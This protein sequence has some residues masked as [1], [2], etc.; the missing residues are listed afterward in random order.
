MKVDVLGTTFTD[1]VVKTD[2]LNMKFD[3]LVFSKH[4][5]ISAGGNGSNVAINLSKNNIHVDYHGLISND[6]GGQIVLSEFNKYKV[7]YDLKKFVKNGSTG[8]SL[9][10]VEKSGE[11]AITSYQGLNDNYD[12]VNIHNINNSVAVC[13]LGLMP[14][15]EKNSLRKTL[16]HTSFIHKYS[17]V[18]T[19]A[20]VTKIKDYLVEGLLSNLDFLF[21]NA[22]EV[23]D[24]ANMSTIQDSANFILTNGVKNVVVT[25]GKD[26]ATL[27]RKNCEPI[28]KDPPLVTVVDTTGAGDAFMS[29]FIME[30]EKS[31]NP[32]QALIK[33]NEL[34]SK[35]VMSIGAINS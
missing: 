24:T 3:D 2:Y 28:H 35:N 19:S 5:K 1:I 25:Q 18:G 11:K 21:L 22:R 17:Y 8:I 32:I 7:N 16:E 33:G 31:R 10:L 34:G 4:A 9:V 23:I 30:F 6:Y 20:N 15:F 14:K 26:G 27:F 12:E 13:G 29:G